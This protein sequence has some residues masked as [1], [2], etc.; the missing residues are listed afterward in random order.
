MLSGL[1]GYPAFQPAFMA[2]S[3]LRF[4]ISNDRE[5]ELKKDQREF[6]ASTKV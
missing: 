1:Y 2:L 3:G 4:T 6:D 5:A